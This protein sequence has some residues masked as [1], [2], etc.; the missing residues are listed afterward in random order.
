MKNYA[1][2]SKIY[3]PESVLLILLSMDL[4]ENMSQKTKTA[5]SHFKKP[6]KEQT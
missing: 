1:W 4:F 5:T 3:V 6:A 2:I